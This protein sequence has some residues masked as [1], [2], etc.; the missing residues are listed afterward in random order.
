MRSQFS[1]SIENL[2]LPPACRLDRLAEAEQWQKRA[3][4]KRIDADDVRVVK[5]VEELS[6]QVE[7]G[8]VTHAEVFLRHPEHTGTVS[9]DLN[10]P[11]QEPLSAPAGWPGI[12]SI[13]FF[14]ISCGVGSALWV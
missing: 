1:K 2:N 7:V 11:I 12:C 9:A 10:V 8:V 6:H 5:Q 13:I 14:F 3:S 4:E